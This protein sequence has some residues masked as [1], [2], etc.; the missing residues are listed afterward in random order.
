MKD[1]VML[2]EQYSAKTWLVVWDSRPTF[3]IDIDNNYKANRKGGGTEE[4]R[5]MRQQM[6]QQLKEVGLI[7]RYTGIKQLK[8]EGREADDIL[9]TLS[10]RIDGEKVFVARDKDLY[11]LLGNDV[12]LYDF[13]TEKNESWFR[14]EYGISPEDW[15]TIQAL[16][17][18][19]TDN[20][21]GV[22]GIGTK[23]AA[24]LVRKCGS[25]D[26]ILDSG[27]I[28]HEDK[29]IVRN[30][31]SLVR[32]CTNC[33]LIEIDS[34]YD[35]VKLRKIFERKKFW[36]LVGKLGVFQKNLLR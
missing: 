16:T 34:K 17:G 1:I 35:P 14:K 29:E 2:M 5:A 12:I 13:L 10:A 19:S 4:E 27:I 7:L 9:A 28:R 15:I 3:R 36:S 18:D 24:S 25:L 20:V 23:T 31:E 30:A 21:P 8:S 22:K 32:L 26:E 33:K 6:K 11:Q